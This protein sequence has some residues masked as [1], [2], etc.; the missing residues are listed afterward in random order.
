M[1]IALVLVALMAMIGAASAGGY[2]DQQLAGNHYGLYY[3]VFQD[4]AH[5]GVSVEDDGYHEEDVEKFVRLTFSTYWDYANSIA[6]HFYGVF[7]VGG[8]ELDHGEVY[9]VFLCEVDADDARYMTREQ[10][11]AYGMR[12]YYYD[13]YEPEYATYPASGYYTSETTYSGTSVV[14]VDTYGDLYEPQDGEILV[15]KQTD[16]ADWNAPI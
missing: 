13:D 16:T 8:F 2:V 6:P 7:R 11:I 5:I 4:Y 10:F 3:K 12:D 1:K 9:E 15:T 14:L